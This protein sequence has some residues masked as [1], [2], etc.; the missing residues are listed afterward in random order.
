[1]SGLAHTNEV[2]AEDGKGEGP[3]ER[4]GAVKGGEEV[5]EKGGDGGVDKD[6]D[7][8]LDQPSQAQHGADHAQ[9]KLDVEPDHSDS[10]RVVRVLTLQ[11]KEVL[12]IKFWARYCTRC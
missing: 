9:N 12:G 11:R 6:V 10:P 1:M 2:E 4:E 8:H 7:D 3:K 5:V